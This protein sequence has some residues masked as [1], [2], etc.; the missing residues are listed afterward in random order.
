[1]SRPISSLAISP[2][3]ARVLASKGFERISDLRGTSEEDLQGFKISPRDVE[4]LKNILQTSA[5]PSVAPS[6]TQ[7]A[8]KMAQGQQIYSTSC[9]PLD[10][11]LGG[12]LRRGH[13]L[14]ISGPPGSPKEALLRSIPLSFVQNSEHVLFVDLSNMTG[15]E[16]LRATLKGYDGLILHHVVNTL[17]DFMV[18]LHHLPALLSAHS[19]VS[20]LVFGSIHFPFQSSPSLSNA[21]RQALLQRLKSTLA[22]LTIRRDLTIVVT[23]QLSTKLLNADGSTA[24]FDTGGLGVMVPQL[25]PVYLPGGRAYRVI[26]VP[27]GRNSGFLKLLSTPSTPTGKGPIAKAQYNFDGEVVYS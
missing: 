20:L 1:M 11:L 26:I 8:A 19:K 23:S 9:S 7:S 3:A 25:D 12:G 22:S 4:Y 10:E 27:G 2:Y 13:V 24:T 21:S 5:T 15:P 17:P 14:E 16:V 6:L 18:F